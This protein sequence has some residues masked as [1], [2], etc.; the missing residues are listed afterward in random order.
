M[1]IALPILLLLTLCA[2]CK[3]A[4]TVTVRPL[5]GGKAFA[6]KNETGRELSGINLRGRIIWGG[7][8]FAMEPQSIP[9][10]PAGA[11]VHTI[12]F[13]HP[14]SALV[15]HGFSEQGRFSAEWM[16]SSRVLFRGRLLGRGEISTVVD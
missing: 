11:D 13:R 12:D 14:V 5:E 9:T 2:G 15:V 16:A 1:R 3:T 8:A 7:K 10:W 4:G 6:L